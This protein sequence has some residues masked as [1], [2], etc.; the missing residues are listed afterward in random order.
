MSL[1]DNSGVTHIVFDLYHVASRDQNEERGLRDGYINTG[2]SSWSQ[3][4]PV[5]LNKYWN[6]SENKVRFQQAFITW[7]L[8]VYD[9]KKKFMLG[10]G[11]LQNQCLAISNKNVSEISCLQSSQE[12]PDDRMMLHINYEVMNGTSN[13]T[14]AS[15]D[16]DIFVCLLCH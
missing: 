10:G 1:G 15:N 16:T 5:E 13:I 3:K 4:L 8:E 7:I 2:I 9:G 14:V 11:S 12:E 6:S